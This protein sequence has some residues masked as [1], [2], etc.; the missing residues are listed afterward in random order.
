MKD[1][2]LVLITEPKEIPSGLTRIPLHL[3]GLLGDAGGG[4]GWMR[5][6]PGLGCGESLPSASDGFRLR[7]E[8]EQD[9]NG[10]AVSAGFSRGL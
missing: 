9:G 2:G 6:S 10:P 7:V 5:D 8:R 1:F 3:A 4:F